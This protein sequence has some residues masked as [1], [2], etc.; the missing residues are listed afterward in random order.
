MTMPGAFDLN[1]AGDSIESMTR[2][3]LLLRVQSDMRELSSLREELGE[4]NRGVVALYAELDDRAE[5]LRHISEL[6]SRFLSYVSHEFRTPLGAIRSLARMLA[7]QVDGTLT[8]EQLVQVNFIDTSALELTDM[9]NDQLDLAKLEAGRITVTPAWFEL[10]EVFLALRGMFKSIQTNPNV[11][12]VFEEPHGIPRL[13]S[14]DRKLTQILRNFV[15]NALKFTPT[16]T[17]TVRAMRVGEQYVRFTVEDTGI[18]I[19]EEHLRH[20][21]EDFTQVDS[22]IQRRVRGT[23]LGL[24]LCQ[25]LAQLLGGDVAVS[26]VV[27]QGS[28]F[29]AQIPII[30]NGSVDGR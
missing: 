21:F 26:S 20:I 25:R 29:S 1:V 28:M 11:T 6:K 30:M 7:S 27:G 18:G 8:A 4:T 23:G 17:V 22:A 16:G 3:Q 19:A 13:F 12:L 9:V 10:C 5:Q 15:S 14:D 24:A 2:E